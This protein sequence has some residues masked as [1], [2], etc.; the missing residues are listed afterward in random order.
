[1]QRTMKTL[2][3][4]TAIVGVLLALYLFFDVFKAKK[5][6]REL[7]SWI[8]IA[9]LHIDNSIPPGLL[10]EVD[11]TGP[12]AIGRTHFRLV[13]KV[14][15][16]VFCRVDTDHGNFQPNE[17]RQ[18]FLKALSVNEDIGHPP[19]TRIR[20]FLQ[21]FPEYKKGLDIVRGEFL[22]K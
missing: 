21:A 15:E 9:V 3:V 8:N 11:N 1:M 2:K 18:I 4:A 6:E 13:F 16:Q 14:G 19:G 20:Y 17:K 12:R 5:E 7:L 22:L 10:I